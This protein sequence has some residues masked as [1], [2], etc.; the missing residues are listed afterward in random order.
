[1]LG[2]IAVGIPA[3]GSA[4]LLFEMVGINHECRGAVDIYGRRPSVHYCTRNC[5]KCK[6]IAQ[7]LKQEMGIRDSRAKLAHAEIR[8][9]ARKTNTRRRHTRTLSPGWTPHDSSDTKIALPHELKPTAYL[10][11]VYPAIACSAKATC[12]CSCAAEKR[13]PAHP[14]IGTRARQRAHASTIARHMRTQSRARTHIPRRHRKLCG[15]QRQFAPPLL[16][17]P[18]RTTLL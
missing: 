15:L 17:G 14:N 11:P 16:A 5:R 12:D 9:R 10:K 18:W 6:C 4:H 3:T 7:H 1:M 13:A 8:W 2:A